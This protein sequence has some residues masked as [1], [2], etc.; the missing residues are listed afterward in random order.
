MAEQLE[1]FLGE[2]EQVFQ[3][4]SIQLVMKNWFPLTL[5]WVILWNFWR[6]L[7]VENVSELR[8]GAVVVW[9]FLETLLE[10]ARIN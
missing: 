3:N 10:N 2:P 5:S 7:N 9:L 6:S 4:I 1:T 8:D